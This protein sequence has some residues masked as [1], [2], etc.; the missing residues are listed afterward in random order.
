[1][2]WNASRKTKLGIKTWCSLVFLSWAPPRK[3][4]FFCCWIPSMDIVI[5]RSFRSSWWGHFFGGI[6]WS[7]CWQYLQVTTRKR[8]QMAPATKDRDDPQ[9]LG[10]LNFEP[11]LGKIG[12]NW[13]VWLGKLSIYIQSYPITGRF[14]F[15]LK[16]RFFLLSVR[17]ISN[18][19]LTELNHESSISNLEW[20]LQ[21]TNRTMASWLSCAEQHRWDQLWSDQSQSNRR[22]PTLRWM[23]GWPIKN[24]IIWEHNPW[25]GGF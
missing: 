22:C 11:I 4:M 23:A 3:T 5:F 19:R 9:A 10:E 25:S 7:P 21:G 14:F 8:H 1:M 2:P 18:V 6:P 15:P 12:R 24:G 17:Y 16:C 20:M 13:C